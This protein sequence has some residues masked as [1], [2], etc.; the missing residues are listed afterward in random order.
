M[1]N[2]GSIPALCIFILFC[3]RLTED[4]S[5]WTGLRPSVASMGVMLLIQHM[6]F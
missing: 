3:D 4:A 1:S 2:T 6:D 5:T